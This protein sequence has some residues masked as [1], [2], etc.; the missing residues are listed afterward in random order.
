MKN[1]RIALIGI[2]ALPVCSCRTIRENTSIQ[3]ADNLKWNKKVSVTLGAIPARTLAFQIPADTL[4]SLENTRFER[5]K[6]G[7]KLSVGMTGGMLDIQA[8]TDPLPEMTYTEESNMER[9]RD[10]FAQ[11]DKAK[12]PT[13]TGILEN[14]SPILKWVSVVLAIIIVIKCMNIWQKKQE[15]M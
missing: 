3:K 12:E 5:E 15:N 8:Q 6:D 7:L 2:V 1:C 4:R 10:Y 9:D 14:I 13:V 11:L